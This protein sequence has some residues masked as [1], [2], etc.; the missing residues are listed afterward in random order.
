MR[1]AGGGLVVWSPVALYGD[2]RQQIDA[3]G[4]VAHVIAPNSLHHLALGEWQAAYP[5]AVFHAAPGLR[6]KRPD[7]TFHRDL[8]DQPD[9]GFEG[10][11]EQVVVRGNKITTEVVFFHVP[12]GTVL[13]TDLVQNYPKGWFRGW[14]A[15][16]ARLDLMVAP[17]ASVPRKFR[18]A[19]T[20][21]RAARSA[22]DVIKGWPAKLV[23]M[24]HGAP[25]T[26]DAQGFLD[27]A[28]RWLFR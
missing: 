10:E 14:R 4:T 20:D 7:I 28:F 17:E 3:L 22:I 8:G 5:A 11:I 24:A 27:R 9:P 23:L 21:R 16:V 26:R 2:L 18:L 15:V 19:F 12:S 25:V 13:F 1:L 6:R